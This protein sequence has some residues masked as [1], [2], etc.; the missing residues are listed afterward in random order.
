[1]EA[2]FWLV[3]LNLFSRWRFLRARERN[4]EEA[5][6]HEGRKGKKGV[7]PLALY[8]KNNNQK[9]W[10]A[11]TTIFDKEEWLWSRT[12]FFVRCFL[13]LTVHNVQ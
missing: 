1:M 7:F 10:Q 4:Y 12:D 8:K 2:L 5:R 11:P 6:A 3:S 9:Q 13:D